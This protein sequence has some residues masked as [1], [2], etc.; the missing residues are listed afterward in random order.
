M[1]FCIKH[2]NIIHKRRS[3]ER[4]S[5]RHQA[6]LLLLQRMF[7]IIISL[8]FLPQQPSHPDT[9]DAYSHINRENNPPHPRASCLGPA[10]PKCLCL[11]MFDMCTGEC[12]RRRR[13]RWGVCMLCRRGALAVA[14]ATNGKPPPT[15][16]SRSLSLSSFV[17]NEG[18][19]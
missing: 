10:R 2:V 11:F 16:R 12:C 7:T 8:F 3:T 15:C 17:P 9:T 13:R 6:M 5:C 1:L 14:L 19:G 4:G 18:N